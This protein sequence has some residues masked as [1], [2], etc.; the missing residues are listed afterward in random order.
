MR[1]VGRINNGGN[2]RGEFVDDYTSLTSGVDGSCHDWENIT[3]YHYWLNDG[4]SSL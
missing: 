1:K 2:A 4:L 3:Y